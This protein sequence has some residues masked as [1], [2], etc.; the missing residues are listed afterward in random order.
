MA[1]AV[2]E[3]KRDEFV[4]AV[5]HEAN[6]GLTTVEAMVQLLL[7]APTLTRIMDT[8][9]VDQLTLRQ[10]L[11]A[12][13]E[14]RS[15]NYRELLTTIAQAQGSIPLAVQTSV[16]VCTIVRREVDRYA[17]HSVGC[18]LYAVLDDEHLTYGVICVPDDSM[19]RPAWVV[20]LAHVVGDS[21]VIDEDT[22]DNSL[23]DALMINGGIPREK[24]ILAYTGE[25]LPEH[26]CE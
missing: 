21:I 2:D 13:S 26:T 7:L 25:T 9:V 3:H 17:G 12:I 23:V 14:H 5:A 18:K 4:N 6:A 10:Y 19:D 20:V 16:D 1:D 8:V 22:T 24:I 15:R 11:T